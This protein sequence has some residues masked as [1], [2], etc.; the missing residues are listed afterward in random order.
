MMRI[1][2]YGYFRS[3]FQD[4]RASCMLAPAAT[5]VEYRRHDLGD[6]LL[7]DPIDYH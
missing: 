7:D 1:A 2:Y 5:R 3:A 4:R 6:G